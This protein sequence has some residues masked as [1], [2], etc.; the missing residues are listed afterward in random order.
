MGVTR[1]NFE[2]TLLKVRPLHVP[3]QLFS[4]SCYYT[5]AIKI[6]TEH[7]VRVGNQTVFVMIRYTEKWRLFYVMMFYF[8][9]M[10]KKHVVTRMKKKKKY[11]RRLC[12]SHPFNF[13]YAFRDVII[14]EKIATVGFKSW[15]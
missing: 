1:F 10:R 13:D 15:W 9:L 7:V 8:N 2:L 3:K 4:A 14:M 6:R 12:Y 5:L 11:Y